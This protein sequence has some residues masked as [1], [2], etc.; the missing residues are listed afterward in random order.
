MNN[1][2][3]LNY[4]AKYFINSGN[5]NL[6]FGLIGCILNGFVCYIIGTHKSLR[7]PFNYLILNLA[8]SDFLVSL[9]VASNSILNYVASRHTG[10]LFNIFDA[11]N[12]SCKFIIFC[13]LSSF[14]STSLTLL[15]IS[16]E[17]CQCIT[18]K[19]KYKMKI[20]TARKAIILIWFLAISSSTTLAYYGKAEREIGYDCCFD[21]IKTLWLLIL[22]LTLSIVTAILPIAFM[23]VLYIYVA[24]KLYVKLQLSNESNAGFT[25][26]RRKYLRRSITVIIIISVFTF[27]TGLPFLLLHTI[28]IIGHNKTFG[29][30]QLHD[31]FLGGTASFL[32]LLSPILNPLLYNLASSPFRKVILSYLPLFRNHSS[33]SMKGQALKVQFIGQLNNITDLQKI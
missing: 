32:F 31:N 15:A 3:V 8:I 12:I 11:M 23:S 20:S 30:F 9:A 7:Q 29:S 28:V 4:T 14:S 13:C 17:R 33:K 2:V 26:K 5:I 27:T 16:V 1:S 10:Q 6:T 18:A 24:Y 21:R 19:Y 25:E 22:G